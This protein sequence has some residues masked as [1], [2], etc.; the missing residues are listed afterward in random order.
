MIVA[1]M[2]IVPL[3]A[4]AGEGS[5]MACPDC[6]HEVSKRAFMC[7]NCG[8]KG[9]V[10]VEEAARLAKAE[11]PPPP[12]ERIKVDFGDHIDFA[13]PV[14]FGDKPF[15]VL[16]LEKMVGLKTLTLS[17]VSTNAPIEYA[18]IEVA[19]NAPLVRFGIDATNLLF[20]VEANE[21]SWSLVSP[22]RL[23]KDAE[24]MLEERSKK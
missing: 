5:L 10:I 14:M 2:L 12:D 17:F 6:G 18:T 8:L 24:K 16:P 21:T 3:M 11:E 22:M 19:D 4:A 7:P 9:E 1:I 15:A 20:R 23:K 13:E